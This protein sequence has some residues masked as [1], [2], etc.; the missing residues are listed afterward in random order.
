MNKSSLVLSLLLFGLVLVRGEETAGYTPESRTVTETFTAKILKVYAFQEGDFEYAAYVVNWN[1]HEVVVTPGGGFTNAT[2]YKEGDTL[3]C[4]M[5]QSHLHVGDADKS[6]ISFYVVSNLNAAEEVQHL[7]AVAAEVK[8]R[9]ERRQT[10]MAGNAKLLGTIAPGSATPAA[11]SRA[12]ESAKLVIQI[13]AN[14][15]VLIDNQEVSDDALTQKLGATAK[16]DE[17]PAILVVADEKAPW[18]KISSVMDQCRKQGLQK[19]SLQSS[20]GVPNN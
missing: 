11:A 16:Q 20:P 10:A 19:F 2:K 7:E 3:R 12:V 1:D 17:K 8:E 14:G 9:R 4:T 18:E 5:Q 6:R 15:A 13:R